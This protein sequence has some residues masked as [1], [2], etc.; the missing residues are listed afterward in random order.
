VRADGSSEV[1]DDGRGIPLG[2]F[3]D[4]GYASA[5]G[6]LATGDILVLYSDGAVER[7]G[8][9]IDRGIERLA[10]L[11]AEQAPSPR[12]LCDRVRDTLRAE[13]PLGDDVA[14]VLAQRVVPAMP[15]VTSVSTG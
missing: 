15:R 1:L 6:S 13:G 10:L 14:L 7:R 12:D 2:V 5:R 8:E 4:T 9:S 11:V 3:V